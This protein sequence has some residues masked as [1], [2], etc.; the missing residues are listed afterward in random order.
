VTPGGIAAIVPVVR[1][2]EAILPNRRVFAALFVAVALLVTGSRAPGIAAAE[3]GVF[4]AADS[5]SADSLRP[6]EAGLLAQTPVPPAPARDYLAEVRAGYTPVNRAYYETRV[7]VQFLGPLYA[8]IVTLLLLFSGLSARFRDIAHALGHRLYVRV[9]VYFVLFATSSAILQL[10]LAWFE[11]FALEH[12]Y[13]LST[14]TLSGWFLDSVK[15]LVFVLVL[16]GVIPLLYAAWRVVR[17]HPRGWWWRLAAGV[18]PIS[19][20]LVMLQPL[21]FEPV[22]NK[23][24][25]LRD[26]SLRG[27]ILALGRRAGIPAKHVFQ[28]DMSRRTRK[29]NAYV[30]GFGGSQRIVLWDT[31]LESLKRDE[32][33]VVMGHEMGHYAL[34]HAWKSILV[35]ALGAFGAFWLVARITGWLLAAFGRHWGADGP[36]DLAAMPAMWLA[37]SL[38]MLLAQP[39]LNALSRNIEHESDVYALELTHDNDAAARAFLK[40]AQDN[41]SNPE[42]AG[43]VKFLLYDHPPLGERIRFAL[44]YRPWE[45]GEPNRYYRAK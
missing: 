3:A 5:V 29:I 9:L 19:F 7:V 11:E 13:G 25:P 6:A 4:V 12:Q 38:V 21:V 1:T 16:L 41:R 32:I 39:G 14:Q 26:A 27:E 8:A 45:R 10:P 23:F 44:T 28:V 31:T 42:P 2:P 20:A 36:G 33:L 35:I 37:L 34:G 18:A 24:E 43:W 30:S 40:L 15:G 22:F 17:A